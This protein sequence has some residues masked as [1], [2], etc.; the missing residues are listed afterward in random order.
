MYEG[1]GRII[2]LR[3]LA[4]LVVVIN[5]IYFAVGYRA[6][7]GGESSLVP[8]SPVEPSL[9]LLRERSSSVPDATPVAEAK[10]VVAELA[11]P[12]QSSVADVAISAPP[13]NTAAEQAFVA[14][15]RDAATDPAIVPP[16]QQTCWELGRFTDEAHAKRLQQQLAAQDIALQVQQRAVAGN[17][18]YWVFLGP[19]PNRRQAL[20]AHRDMQARK[21]DSFLI[22]EGELENAVSLG[23]FSLESGAQKMQQQRKKQGLDAQLRAVPRIRTEWWALFS[24]PAAQLSEA[25]R[26]TITA[27][28]VVPPLEIKSRPCEPIA[29]TGKLD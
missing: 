18:D 8:E 26:D 27:D 14:D 29:N 11:A 21:I 24:I 28:P 9:L 10:N 20:A 15:Q 2:M 12:T 19:Y 25:V 16:V 5:L 4:V 13:E 22:A 23:L 6:S 1:F 17:P 7:V 3:W